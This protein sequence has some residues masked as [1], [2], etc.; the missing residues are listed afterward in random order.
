MPVG[1]HVRQSAQNLPTCKAVSTMLAMSLA[2]ACLGTCHCEATSAGLAQLQKALEAAKSIEK[3]LQFN[4]IFAG[5]FNSAPSTTQGSVD[6]CPRQLEDNY[7]QQTLFTIGPQFCSSIFALTIYAFSDPRRGS[8]LVVKQKSSLNT[9][10][11]ERKP[12]NRK[13]FCRDP[14]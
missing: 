5:N 4:M 10:N 7:G 8:E 11:F 6:T 1:Q 13:G 14:S 2:T 3:K 12:P 9:P